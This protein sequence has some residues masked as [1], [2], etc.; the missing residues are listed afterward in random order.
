[1]RP[2]VRRERISFR[3]MFSLSAAMTLGQTGLPG[4]WGQTRAEETIP[5][6]VCR[7][8]LWKT[9]CP[10]AGVM[11]CTIVNCNGHRRG[12]YRVNKGQQTGTHRHR[13]VRATGKRRATRCHR[14]ATEPPGK[15]ARL[16]QTGRR[17]SLGRLDRRRLGGRCPG[18]VCS[19]RLDCSGREDG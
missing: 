1:M 15:A 11:A 17:L 13:P 8:R 10:R 3:E 18:A 12:G 19:R 2:L 16:G 4:E 6:T 5:L 7:R 9:L 14:T